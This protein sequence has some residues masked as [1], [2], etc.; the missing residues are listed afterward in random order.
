MPKP[1]TRPNR[2]HY[3]VWIKWAIESGLLGKLPPRYE[4]DGFP[5]PQDTEPYARQL[6]AELRDPDSSRRRL[7]QIVADARQFKN[8]V[9]ARRKD[10]LRIIL[11]TGRPE[12]TIS[13][14]PRRRSSAPSDQ[15]RQTRPTRRE[16]TNPR[17]DPMWDDWLDSL[18]MM[19][20]VSIVIMG[21]ACS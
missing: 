5:N 9:E 19:A 2:H 11:A 3:R 13:I 6:L 10:N 17:L 20:A 21:F 15:E 16:D 8:W 4:P 18:K 1:E 12:E 7:K 14:P